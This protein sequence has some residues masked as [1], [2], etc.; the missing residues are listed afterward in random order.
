MIFRN[1]S[2]IR[3]I[4]QCKGYRSNVTSNDPYQLKFKFKSNDLRF[5]CKQ[6][7][8]RRGMPYILIKHIKKK[9]NILHVWFCVVFK[10]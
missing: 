7:K 2:F 8:D 6:L 9:I 1:G 5:V 10:I 3:I 4:L